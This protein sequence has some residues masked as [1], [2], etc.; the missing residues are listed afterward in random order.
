MSRL[1]KSYRRTLL[2]GV[3][4][5]AVSVAQPVYADD[6]VTGPKMWR[7]S[8][9]WLELEGAYQWVYGAKQPWISDNI[10]GVLGASQSLFSVRPDT[11]LQGRVEVGFKVNQRLDMA[12]SYTGLREHK[13][14]SSRS[15]PSYLYNVLG[16]TKSYYDNANVET[17]STLHVVDFEVGYEVGLGSRGLARVHAGIRFAHFSNDTD[18]D[19]LWP[20]TSPYGTESLNNKTWGIGPRIGVS[21][22][23]RLMSAGR[24]FFSLVGGLSGSVLF[25]KKS[26][27][28]NQTFIGIPSV[29]YNDDSSVTIMNVEGKLGVSYA[30]PLGAWGA[31]ITVG[32]RGSAWWNL[33]N[34][35]TSPNQFAT[36]FPTQFPGAGKSEGN[37][38]YHG[39]F[40][41]FRINF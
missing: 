37:R 4:A 17:R 5:A 23:F 22:K 9:F 19:L 8:A 21:G 16:P 34:M 29:S 35:Q 41:S 18:T 24:G 25:G 14:S 26:T 6:T 12:L 32:Y 39:P 28:V 31:S 30:F 3:A 7:P 40:L 11:A 15:H 20:G 36:A 10:P 1:R 27:N 33:A 38:F 13:K 2:A